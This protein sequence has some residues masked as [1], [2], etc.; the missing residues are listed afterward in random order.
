MALLP[1]PMDFPVE[2]HGDTLV[3]GVPPVL[4]VGNRQNFKQRVLDEL[5]HGE[6]RF[7]IDFR[8]TAYIDSSGLGALVAVGKR[9]REQK[10]ELRISNLN[11]DLKRIFELSGIDRL[12]SP[13]ELDG[14]ARGDAGRPA[15]RP[16]P[17]AGPLFGAADANVPEPDSPA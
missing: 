6:K 17:N 5:G 14:G 12:F 9:I 13:D 7:L 4:V 1:G 2:R 15:P 8:E 16:S 11:D 10:G 3:V